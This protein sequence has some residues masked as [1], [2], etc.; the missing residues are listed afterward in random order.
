MEFLLYGAYGYTGELITA[1]ADTFGLQPVLAGRNAEKLQALADQ[2][3]FASLELDLDDKAALEA[4]LERF[5]LVLHAAGPFKYTAR[6][7]LEACIATGTHYLDITGEI[8]VFE[9]AHSYDAQAKAKNIMLMSGVGFDVVPTDCLAAFLKQEMPDA[10]DL[11][12]AFATLGGG[13]SRGT[14]TT[15]VEGLGEGSARRIDGKITRVPMGEHTMT[16]DFGPKSLF[17]MSIPWGDV[18]TAYYTTGIPNIETFTSVHPKAYQRIK[19]QKY[20]AWFL[21]LGFVKNLMK[22][23]VQKRPAGPSAEKRAKATSVVWGQVSNAQ[24]QHKVGRLETLEGYTLT[25]TTALM[26]S[27]KV[28]ESDF[29]P[30]YQTPAGC[31]GANLIMEIAASKLS[32]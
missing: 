12:L 7:M 11:K 32:L 25:A 20:F 1:M 5:P 2:Y 14:A 13:V 4:A 24:G 16:V 3:D 9:L 26:I 29:K 22:Q 28:L 31:Y 6:P 27:K 30:G 23:Q 21:R 8:E 18:S 15:M 17:V 19:W 10:Q